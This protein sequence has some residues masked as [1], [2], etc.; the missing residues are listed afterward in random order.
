MNWLLIVPPTDKPIHAFTASLP[1]IPHFQKSSWLYISQTQCLR[2]RPATST[3]NS[4]CKACTGWLSATRR[5]G[6]SPEW[7]H[8]WGEGT[9][10]TAKGGPERQSLVG[11][12]SASYTPRL[13]WNRGVLDLTL[14]SPPFPFHP[15]N[16]PS[17][18]PPDSPPLALAGPI[19]FSSLFGAAFLFPASNPP[20]ML[21]LSP[22]TDYKQTLTSCFSEPGR[23]H[24]DPFLSFTLSLPQTLLP[25]SFFFLQLHRFCCLSFLVNLFTA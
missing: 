17:L 15:F 6:W 10:L 19:A 11:G 23:R 16:N 18:L 3:Q 8:Y 7:S 2:R 4:N 12:Q 13:P 1:F 20:K 24:K 25:L 9:S 14:P 5:Q 21:S 22:S